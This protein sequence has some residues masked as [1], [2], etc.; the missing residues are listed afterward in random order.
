MDPHAA[1]VL[2]RTL[3][4]A[5][6]WTALLLGAT[7]LGQELVVFAA[8][9]LTESFEAIAVEFEARHEGV[10]VLLS[11]D[12]SSTLALQILHG[13]PADVFASANPE[14]MQRVVDA[15]DVAGAPRVLVTNRLVA[16]APEDGAVRRLEDLAKPGVR[17]VLAA[18]EVPV[19]V[20]ARAAIASLANA[21]GPDFPDR[22]FANLVSEEPNVRQVSARVE[23]G[24]VDAA[25][26]YATDA[27][28]AD[29]VATIPIPDAHNV[30]ATYPIAVLARSAHA[31]LAA[32]FVR[33][34]GS[35]EARAI[36][37]AHG[38]SMPQ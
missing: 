36:L 14:Q 17:L 32:S 7:A 24:E 4:V 16:I 5:V 1:T 9:S 12:G 6:A 25:I 33:F 15:G 20:Y 31:E 27:R 34:A 11:F 37:A 26:V 38:F 30:T 3:R 29:G 13:A 19:G 8:S 2:G 35:D 23:L 28:V 22:V 10:D 21:Y 18:P